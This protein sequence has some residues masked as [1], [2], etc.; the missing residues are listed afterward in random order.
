MNFIKHY[1]RAK[2]CLPKLWP[3]QHHVWWR[4]IGW[5][6]TWHLMGVDIAIQRVSTRLSRNGYLLR[7]SVVDLEQNYADLSQGFLEFFP[8]LQ[9]FV[10][11]QRDLLAHEQTR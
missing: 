6:P 5:V 8:Q 3:M 1:W 9:S 11:E 4:K 10:L 2:I 7:E